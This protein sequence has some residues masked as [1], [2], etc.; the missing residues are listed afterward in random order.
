MALIWT[1]N[2]YKVYPTFA[3]QL[4]G[5]QVP[6]FRNV[7]YKYRNLVGKLM[8]GK[9]TII[10]LHSKKQL[11]IFSVTKWIFCADF[12]LTGVDCDHRLHALK[13]FPLHSPI[14]HLQQRSQFYLRKGKN[15]TF[16]EAKSWKLEVK[17]M[18]INILTE[19]QIYQMILGQNK[20]FV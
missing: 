15:S 18:M 12:L 5:Y 19:K 6:H 20:Q 1:D 17:K 16:E 8:L 13:S 4:L 10:S 9:V 11:L 7:H 3:Q 2:P 14:K